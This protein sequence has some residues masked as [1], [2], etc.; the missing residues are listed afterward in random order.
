MPAKR[1]FGQL[2]C[3]MHSATAKIA[4]ANA[5]LLH[6]PRDQAP[7]ALTTDASN[8][9]IG[10]VLEQEFQGT[11]RPI[12]FFSKKLQP[13]ETCYSVF[14]RELLAV[15]LSIRRFRHF[16]EESPFTIY[17]DHKPLVQALVRQSDPWSPRQQRHLSYISE[18]ST[19]IHHVSGKDNTIYNRVSYHTNTTIMTPCK[20]Y[21]VKSYFRLPEFGHFHST[22][23]C[24]VQFFGCACGGHLAAGQQVGHVLDCAAVTEVIVH[25]SPLLH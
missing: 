17:T 13:A 14:D 19:D 4:L 16:L 6:H 15:Y 10:A 25:V 12:A 20:E 3:R 22:V 9:A 24:F 2:S 23:F 11:W 8:T 21:V 7:T 5:T 1:F 18:Y